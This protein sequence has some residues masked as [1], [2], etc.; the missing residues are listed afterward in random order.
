MTLDQ[1]IALDAIVAAGTFR[2][3]ADRLNKA[4]SAISHQIRKL[5]DELGFDLFTREDYRPRLT[6][7]GEVYYRE[8]LR[9][10]EQVRVLK[11]AATGLAGEQEAEIRIAATATMALDPFLAILGSVSRAWPATHVRLYEELMGG[12]VARLMASEADMILAGLEGVP[13][14]E[15]ETLPVGH[16]TILPVAHRDFPAASRPGLRSRR[17]MQTYT[18]VVVSGTGGEAF[19]Q[20]RDLMSGGRRWTVTGFEAKRSIISAGLGWGGMPAHLIRDELDTG[21]FTVLDVEGFPPRHTQIFAIR[22]RDRPMGTVMNALWD[23]WQGQ[24]AAQHIPD[25]PPRS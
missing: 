18:Q 2:G 23:A 19:T 17:E 5:E 7:N 11:S 3:A 6:E 20:S 4:Q 13:V 8:A 21:A 14:D 12:P 15:V 16:V 22:R 24:P 9:V 25:R 10:L 1:L